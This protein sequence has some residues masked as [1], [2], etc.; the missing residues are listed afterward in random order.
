MAKRLTIGRNPLDTLVAESH[1]DAVV[2]DLV[3]S[4]PQAPAPLRP[5]EAGDLQSLLAAR[6]A[7]NQ[8]LR[9]QVEKLKAQ[10]QE[11]KERLAQAEPRW[12]TLRRLGQ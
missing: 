6:E 7:E 1:L 8:S 9:Q 5:E 3:T 10:V 12:V 2:P 11:L 4:Q